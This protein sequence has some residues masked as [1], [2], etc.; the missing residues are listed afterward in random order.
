MILD[1]QVILQD[2]EKVKAGLLRPAENLV[3]TKELQETLS[4]TWV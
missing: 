3:L 1:T 4:L 2:T